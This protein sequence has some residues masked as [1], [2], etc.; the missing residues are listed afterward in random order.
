MSVASGSGASPM[1]LAHPN[2]EELEQALLDAAVLALEELGFLMALEAKGGRVEDDRHFASVRVGFRGP[3]RGSLGLSLDRGL[4]P[5]LAANMLGVEGEP[6][7]ALQGDA[8][9]EVA[10]V[11]CGNVLPTVAGARAVFDLDR[12]VPWS[13]GTPPGAL[14]VRLDVEEGWAEVWLRVEGGE[15]A[16]R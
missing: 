15:V 5:R 3:C 14:K 10:N 8:L 4:L 7:D 1:A 13:G 11:I 6:S 2:E 9:G 12:A 16:G